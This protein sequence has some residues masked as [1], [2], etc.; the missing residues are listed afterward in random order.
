MSIGNR[1]T[2]MPEL[3]IGTSGY[4]YL[5]WKGQFYPD[6]MDRRDFLGY[7]SGK[8]ST[9]ELNFSY[10]RMPTV[11][12]LS[13]ILKRSEG[14]LD[15]SIKAHE[16]ITHKI[17]AASWKD[18]VKAYTASLK[19]LRDAERLV[20]VL[21]QFPYSFH[22]MPES[23]R[24]LDQLLSEMTELP[25]VVEFRNAE[26]LNNRVF[27][28]L[29]KRSVGYCS[30]DE[31]QLKGLPPSLDIV[32]SQMAYIRFHGRNEKNWWGS[33]A[34]ARFDYLYSEDELKAWIAR[35]MGMLA[36][37]RNMRIYFNNHRRGQAPANALVLE[38]LLRAEGV[39]AL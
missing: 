13:S 22:Y 14:R 8:F 28:A 6:D 30:V 15:F 17:D 10:Y 16:S 36:S 35:I 34:A 7:Y 19:P 24:Y 1:E 11:S 37:A 4:D 18:S 12:Q 2:I 29:R 33:D 27:D 5:D 39:N 3:K 25:L 26:W 32:T 20:A 23:R 21:L 9:V 31:P 38:K